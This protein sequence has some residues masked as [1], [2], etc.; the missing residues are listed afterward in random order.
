VKQA[1]AKK[2]AREV[3]EFL[4]QLEA[5]AT[6][7]KRVPGATALLIVG[8]RFYDNPGPLKLVSVG[9]IHDRLEVYA[10]APDGAKCEG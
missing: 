2:P 5:L 1:K 3:P 10:I 9:R 8:Q 6:A 4:K 7:A